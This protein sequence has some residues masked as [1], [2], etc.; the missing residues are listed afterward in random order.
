MFIYNN[1]FLF[2]TDTLRGFLFFYYQIQLS[3]NNYLTY[4]ILYF[5][6]TLAQCFLSE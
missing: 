6:N 1:F 5:V 3:V 4:C 2:K